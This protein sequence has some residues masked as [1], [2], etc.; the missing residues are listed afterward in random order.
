MRNAQVA[1]AYIE[2]KSVIDGEVKN[3]ADLKQALLNVQE[4]SYQL[5]PELCEAFP[6]LEQVK[7]KVKWLKKMY[8]STVE[9]VAYSGGSRPK[10]VYTPAFQ[11]MEESDMARDP[12]V[13]HEELLDSRRPEGNSPHSRFSMAQRR[14]TEVQAPVALQVKCTQT[15]Q[16]TVMIQAWMMEQVSRVH[17]P[18][19]NTAKH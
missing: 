3:S 9:T 11:I 4:R 2:H 18:I 1:A 8:S 17:A 19:A 12:L 6:D 10:F 7:S 5:A 13:R 16:T 15:M 14:R